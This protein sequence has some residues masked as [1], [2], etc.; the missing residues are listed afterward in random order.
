VCATFASEILRPG[1]LDGVSVLLAGAAIG[2]ESQAPAAAAVR[3]ACSELGAS[4]SSCELGDGGLDQEA[5]DQAVERMLEAAGSIDLLV[6]D[7]A[8]VFARALR[9]PARGGPRAALRACLDSTWNV[10]RAVS[11]L[12]FVEGERGGRIVLLA[13]PGDGGEHADAAAAGLEN[14][15]R[16]LSVE[17]ARR[18]ITAVAIACSSAT[19]TD[20]AAAMTAYLASPAGAYFSGCLLELGGAVSRSSPRTARR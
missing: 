18:G 5:M 16:T 12:A 10:T 3:A 17:W 20:E 9:S 13:P 2:D 1:L 7:A 6:V 4:V 15:A 14:L 19:D 8:G 11:R